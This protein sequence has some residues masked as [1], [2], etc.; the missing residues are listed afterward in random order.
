MVWYDGG[1]RQSLVLTLCPKINDEQQLL[2]IVSLPPGHFRTWVAVLVCGPLFSC[3]STCF[4]MWVVIFEWGWLSSCLGGC[5]V[6]SVVIHC[7]FPAMLYHVIV[8]CLL[9]VT[10]W[11]VGIGTG[12]LMWHLAWVGVEQLEWGGG[13]YLPCW[14]AAVD[15]DEVWHHHHHW[16]LPSLAGTHEMGFL[17]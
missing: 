6:S 17:H 1:G 12:S 3:V 9:C 2:S 16:C 7:R 4:C 10:L 14:A 15:S 13:D 5:C 8:C 11:V